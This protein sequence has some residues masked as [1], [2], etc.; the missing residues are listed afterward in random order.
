MKT[1]IALN[2]D[3]AAALV[4]LGKE[5]AA[6]PIA[7]DGRPYVDFIPNSFLDHFCDVVER[8]GIAGKMSIVPA[9]CGRGD[10]ANGLDGFSRE[11][12]TYW[13]DT[14]KRRLSSHFSFGPEM[15]THTRAVNL[16]DGSLLDENE[17]VWSQHQTRETLTPYITRALTIGRDAGINYTGVTSPWNFGVEVEDEYVAAV[18]ASMEA[19][20]GRHDSWYFCRSLH[21]QPNA[22]PWVALNDGKYRVAA[23]PG[24]VR[25][26]FYLTM[27]QS[28]ASLGKDERISA[29]ADKFIT[30]D[31]TAGYIIDVLNTNGYPM[32]TSHWQNFFS[33]G[34]E[35]GLA[36]LAEVAARVE[37][38][39][40]DRVVWTP[41]EVLM[42]QTLGI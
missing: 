39:L 33:N 2:I 40:S 20:Y 13:L 35:S 11:D 15:I 22:R 10:I 12:L 25:D 4:Y 28:F 5:H 16:A 26:Y 32:I 14:V 23:M 8:Y 18:A 7:R 24:T 41:Y 6:S 17:A 21:E 27:D 36:V 3:D 30:A 42:R 34:A 9:P 38:H 19:V 31:G 1:P 37:K 29:V